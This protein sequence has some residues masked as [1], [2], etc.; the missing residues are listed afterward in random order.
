[1]LSP[2][3][4][5]V[6]LC[7]ALCVSPAACDGS[8][9]PGPQG[10]VPT[11]DASSSPKDSGVHVHT[12]AGILTYR[13]DTLALLSDGSD[14]TSVRLVAQV[15]GLFTVEVLTELPSGGFSASPLADAPSLD[16]GEPR[17]P[18]GVAVA[19][20]DGDGRNDVFVS[21]PLGNWVAQ[22]QSDGS[23]AG[24]APAPELATFPATSEPRF[25][26]VGKTLVLLGTAGGDLFAASRQVPGGLWS[27]PAVTPDNPLIDMTI[28]V[29]VTLPS[30]ASATGKLICPVYWGRYGKQ[31][32]L[33]DLS[34]IA[35]GI[36]PPP[37]AVAYT[38]FPPYVVPF[39]SFDHFEHLPIPGCEGSLVGV[40]VFGDD[41][42]S[43]PRRIERLTLDAS[44]YTIS[45]LATPFDV[46]TFDL[47]AEAN[48]NAIAGVIGSSAA[49]SVFAAYRVTN[50]GDWVSLGSVPIDFDWRPVPAPGFGDG[51]GPKDAGVVVPKTDGVQLL[52]WRV[53]PGDASG[54]NRYRFVHYDGYTMRV[55]TVG[56]TNGT[57]SMA[58]FDVAQYALHSNRSDLIAP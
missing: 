46:I 20:V 21:D 25:E 27:A 51:T 36:I 16:A 11:G 43:V 42:T 44:S 57:A 7:V 52:G 45:E 9:R 41:V 34:Q 5:M 17:F 53:S 55:L 37:V 4:G 2:T 8:R 6:G 48:G 56:V 18:I 19:D 23:F 49:G 15:M 58:S 28:P 50:C 10:A 24:A 12:G 1:M 13:R 30:E 39:D 29:C 3:P 31:F 38:F 40:G 32:F 26:P 33:Y 14:R 47:V 54:S 35:Q 22:G